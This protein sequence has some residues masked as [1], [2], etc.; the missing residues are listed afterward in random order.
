M[1]KTKSYQQMKDEILNEPSN[2]FW[3]KNAIAELENRD[4]LDV[5][6]DLTLLNDL[7]TERYIEVKTE[8]ELIAAEEESLSE[9]PVQDEQ[10]NG[11]NKKGLGNRYAKIGK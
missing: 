10:D 1:K 6:A 11:S 5:L 9:T 2:S 3:I 8:N 4:P 7:M